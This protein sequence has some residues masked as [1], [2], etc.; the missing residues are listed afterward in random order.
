MRDSAQCAPELTMS[1]LPDP[2]VQRRA[3]SGAS[4]ARLGCH[5]IL[6]LLLGGQL[7]P[8]SSQQALEVSTLRAKPGEKVS[9]YLAV[10][11]ADGG[12]VRVP[13]SLV[14]G[15]NVGPTLALVA[16]EHGTEYT[17]ILALHELLAQIDPAEVAGALILVHMANPP[18]FS[19]RRL[20]RGDPDD[21]A[22]H[23]PGDSN[24]TPSERIAW[25]L[26]EHVIKPATHVI[27]MHAGD[28]NEALNSYAYVILTGDSILDAA[29]RRLT[30]AYGKDRI[31]IESGLHS[32]SAGQ[33]FFLDSY[34]L[35][36][37]K[38]AF[39]PEFGG[40]AS[41]D[42]RYVNAHVTGV[43]SVMADLGMIIG[44]V[45][46][47]ERPIWFEAGVD[48]RVTQEGLWRSEVRLG[49]VVQ[50]G[51]ALGHVLD[52]FGRVIEVVRS[53]VRGEVLSVIGTPPIATGGTAVFIGRLP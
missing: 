39:L 38:P 42:P 22:V 15:V 31:V 6:L 4:A 52:S 32:D 47:P 14:N 51:E 18:A 34:A 5:V 25:V 21:L 11:L 12:Q 13:V 3:S 46:A 50:E 20:A 48:V 8:A 41:S 9:G 2:I 35:S 17:P 37:G 7:T 16:G 24:G 10:E 26:S 1:P 29:T 44:P 36:L 30:L 43:R 23:F 53:P 49:D 19:A 33:R 28:G 40:L 27:N 45:L